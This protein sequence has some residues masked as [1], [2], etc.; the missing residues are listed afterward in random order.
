MRMPNKNILDKLYKLSVPFSTVDARVIT[1]RYIYSL[2]L[3]VPYS[4]HDLVQ[5]FLRHG[6]ALDDQIAFDRL[7]CYND[8]LNGC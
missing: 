6:G 8:I 5:R 1:T 7:D 3:D 4:G 2:Y